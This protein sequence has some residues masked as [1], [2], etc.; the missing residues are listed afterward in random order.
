M[1]EQDG[2]VVIAVR[3]N[4]SLHV[5]HEIFGLKTEIVEEDNE[6]AVDGLVVRL[7][8]RD[9]WI[10][11]FATCLTERETVLSIVKSCM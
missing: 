1:Q 7:A 2:G 11:T 4:M 6:Y 5:L 10:G 3:N 8:R 9:A